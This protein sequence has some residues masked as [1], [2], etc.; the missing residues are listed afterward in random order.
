[1]STVGTAIDRV[2]GRLKVTGAARYTA[3]YAPEHL[4]YGAPVVSAV[5]KGR[6]IGIR[7]K[8]AESSPGVIAVL[9][10]DNS[11]RLQRTTNDFG[12][13]TKLGEARVL[14]EDDLVHYAGQYLALVVAETLE[15]ATAAAALWSPS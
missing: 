15:Q 10:R 12:A 11:P 7:T 8:P 1:M 4:T 6:V 13:W 2:E 14:F 9:T 5:A 3:D